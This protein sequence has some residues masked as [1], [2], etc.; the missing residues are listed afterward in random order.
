VLLVALAAAEARAQG[1]GGE[2]AAEALFL[3]GKRLVAAGKIDEGCAKLAASHAID[4]AAGTLIHLADCHEKGGRTATA[5]ATFRE[6]TSRAAAQGRSDW[7]D[8]ARARAAELEPKL[9]RL[10]IA[11]PAGVAVRLDAELVPAG[12][13]GSPLPVDPGEHRVE[14]SA[15]GRAPWGT[16]VRI[17]AGASS[18]TI[19]VP[20]LAREPT[21][22]TAATAAPNPS[23]PERADGSTQR[24]LGWLGVGAGGLALGVGAIAGLVAIG[25]NSDSTRACPDDGVCADAAAREANDA[26]RTAAA[27]STVAFVAG[28][29]LA[30]GGLVL[31][32]TAPAAPATRASA[33]IVI[34]PTGLQL[35]GAW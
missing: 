13:L 34:A 32:L 33:R 14:A 15:A 35:G 16:T 28:G 3:E 10:T 20:E 1:T 6:A 11:A 4:P 9:A 8:L 29:V 21:G 31:V 23:G 27:V 7:A 5:W 22:E 12:A 17:A 2:A 30:A 25:K 26:A 18:T 19:A 24:T